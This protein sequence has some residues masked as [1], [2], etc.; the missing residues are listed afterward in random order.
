MFTSLKRIIRSGWTSFCRNSGLSAA[1]VFIM[2]MTITLITS[3]FL[4]QEATKF[5]IVKI[6]EKVDVSVYF[7]EEAPEK[8]ILELQGELSKMPEIKDV[9]YISRDEALEIFVQK[10]ENDQNLM[11][12]LKETGN[13]FLAHLNVKTFEAN[14]YEIVSKFLENKSFQNLIQEVDYYQRKPIIERIFSLTANINRAGIIFSLIFGVIAVLIAFNTIRLAIYNLK[15][16]VSI[17]RLV[18]ASNWFIRGP[19]LVQGAISG[20]I[21]VLITLL[22]TTAVCYFLNPK[23]EALT[24]GL[25]IFGYFIDNFWTII[26]IQLATGIGIGVFSSLIA[27]RKYL[28]V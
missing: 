14:Q 16:E 27:M 20:I 21:A 9:E 4:L 28:E 18:G 5:L 3:L 19:F 11:E 25:N 12:S 22:I 23:I 17:M 26:L 15:E 7:K 2:V 10:H 13:P 8:D 6:Q 1:T 24:P